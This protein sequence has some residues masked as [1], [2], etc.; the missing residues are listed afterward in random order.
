MVVWYPLWNLFS[1]RETWPHGWLS[2]YGTYVLHF[3]LRTFSKELRFRKLWLQNYWK[4]KF[5]IAISYN[6]VCLFRRKYK[7]Q[8]ATTLLLYGGL[9]GI[10]DSE[11]KRDKESA[12]N[13]LFHKCLETEA[14]QKK[15]GW[16]DITTNSSKKSVCC[17]VY[18]SIINEKL[19]VLLSSVLY[20]SIW[21][22]SFPSSFIV[23]YSFFLD[24]SVQEGK[25]QWGYPYMYVKL[26]PVRQGQTTTPGTTC[27]TL[28]DKGWFS[29]AHK[30]KPTYA[31]AVR[32]W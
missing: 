31:E 9:K 23:S 21:K 30:H 12:L 7:F 27:P 4:D 26:Q 6:V 15:L 10:W 32:S 19:S 2:Q 25:V 24:N 28:L 1:L 13:L 11:A 22:K 18:L 8:L 14:L 5:K 20:S 17:I 16:E 3:L 29:L